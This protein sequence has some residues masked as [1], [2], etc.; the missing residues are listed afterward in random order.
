[1]N[2][3]IFQIPIQAK[4]AV[5]N[6]LPLVVPA[7]MAKLLRNSVQSKRMK[8]RLAVVVFISILHI[9]KNICLITLNIKFLYFYAKIPF[10]LLC[11]RV[12]SIAGIFKIKNN[13]ETNV[14][15]EI[16]FLKLHL[17]MSMLR[18]FV[19]T[20]DTME[21]STNAEEMQYNALLTLDIVQERK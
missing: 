4:V 1:M 6:L 5:E 18:K 13:V 8:K 9:S 2:A 19:R 12:W 20:K 17:I 7:Q 11:L 15:A 21:R 3:N 10:K 16:G 14:L